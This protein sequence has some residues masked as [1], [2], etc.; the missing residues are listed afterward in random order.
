MWFF[1]SCLYFIMTFL[2]CKSKYVN[3]NIYTFIYIQNLYIYIKSSKFQ[4]TAVTTVDISLLTTWFH[5]LWPILS[6]L[7]KTGSLPP[8]L[9]TPICF[10]S[11]HNYYL[12]WFILGFCSYWEYWALNSGPCTSMLT[13]SHSG[14]LFAFS[15][16]F[17]K[18]SSF[19]QGQP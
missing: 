3:C 19:C 2:N 7:Q 14:A 6:S 16:S 9:H 8:A 13:L 4:Q 1:C 12:A 17:R 11:V 15:L 18:V 10:L 5:L